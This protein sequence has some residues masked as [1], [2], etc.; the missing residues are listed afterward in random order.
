MELT[1]LSSTVKIKKI[2]EDD[3]SGV[4]EIEGL[5]V[6]Y[7]LTL[8]NALR[9]VLLSS[10][11]GAAITYIK[12]KN[13]PHEFMALSGIKETVVDITLN[14][15]K[16]RFKMHTNEPQTLF[17]KVKGPKEV[18]ASDI[19]ENSL[20]EIINK[21]EHLL[22]ITDKNTTFEAELTIERGL[23]YLPVESRKHEKLP[24]GAIALDALFSPVI[25][26]SYEVEN[27]RVGDRT[28]YNKLKLNI[29]TDG[30]ILPSVALRK[31]ASILKDHFEKIMEIG[32]EAK[33]ENIDETKE[34]KKEKEQKESKDSKKE[35]EDK[36]KSKKKSKK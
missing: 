36:E 9:R 2:K 29:E 22:T 19:E 8:G 12:I 7:G 21:D 18:L 33:E 10:L 20:V 24:I 32:G 31:A 23:G 6:G 14:F 3:F 4:F 17:L 30:T 13:V 5:F 35:K 15:K 26:V 28:D 27:M 34:V 1:H 16:L 11:P 25:K